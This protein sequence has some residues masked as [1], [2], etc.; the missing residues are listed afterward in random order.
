MPTNTSD[1]Q[2]IRDQVDTRF[3]QRREGLRA[4]VIQC[5]AATLNLKAE[6]IA[7]DVPLSSLGAQSLDFLDLTFR[8]EREFKIKLARDVFLRAA[9]AGQSEPRDPGNRLSHGVIER[10]RILL[11]EVDPEKVANGM[12]ATDLSDLLTVDSFCRMVAWQ[13]VPATA[14]VA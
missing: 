13:Q 7:A 5:V 11:P 8:L 4:V 12:S 2:E 6:E 9:E 10:L 14:P 3:E 1:V